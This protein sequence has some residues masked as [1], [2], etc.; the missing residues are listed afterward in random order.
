MACA[1]SCTPGSCTTTR[2]LPWRWMIGSATPSSLMRLR[3]VPTFCSIASLGHACCSSACGML[4][5]RSVLPCDLAAAAVGWLR[6][7]Q[8]ARLRRR[9]RRMLQRG[10]DAVVGAALDRGRSA[11]RLSRSSTRMSSAV[12]SKRL[13][14]AAFWST[15]IRKCTPPCRSR[16]SSIGLRADL[17]QPVRHGRGQVERDDVVAAQR[18]AQRVGGL[19]L[20]VGAGAGAP[21]GCRPSSISTALGA[22]PAFFSAASTRACAAPRRPSQPRLA[23]TC[24]DGILRK[25]VGQRVQRAQQQDDQDDDVFPARVIQA[26]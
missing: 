19:D 9:R 2:S 6:G 24:T 22:T 8:L 10:D 18:V 11:T 16:P 1:V 7:D 15:C 26:S 14:S 23:V 25:D 17:L 20:H 13:S 4:H 5:R 12:A 21:A 3:S